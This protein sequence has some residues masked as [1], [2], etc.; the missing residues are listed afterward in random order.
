MPIAKRTS[1]KNAP[2]I[3]KKYS[4]SGAKCKVTFRLPKQ[5]AG[6]GK[7]V[8]VVGDF[9][10]WSIKTNQMNKLKNG[11][12]KLDIDLEPGKEYRFKYLVDGDRWENDWGA[13]KYVTN[14]YGSDDS[15]VV[16]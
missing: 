7:N 15:V 6:E 11:E 5:A 10:N 4:K 3:K 12:F 9:N 8:F 1:S 16:V 13:D 2:K 14:I